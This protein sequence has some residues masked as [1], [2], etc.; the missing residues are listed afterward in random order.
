MYAVIPVYVYNVTRERGTRV[1]HRATHTNVL[2]VTRRRDT[3]RGG[4]EKGEFEK[5]PAIF[6]ASIR[7]ACSYAPRAYVYP[8][9][10][11]PRCTE[12]LFSQRSDE[13]LSLS[14]SFPPC[15]RLSLFL[16]LSFPRL[17]PLSRSSLQYSAVLLITVY[18]RLASILILVLSRF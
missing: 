10:T 9:A 4:A 18:L 5:K 12:H 14:I 13:F 16:S 7:I 3:R 11:S 1:I 2:T 17:S 15:A 6:R 8:R